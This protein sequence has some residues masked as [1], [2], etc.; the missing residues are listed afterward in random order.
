MLTPCWN[1]IIVK[2]LE[3][4]KSSGTQVPDAL[5]PVRKCKI[6]S[7]GNK[8]AENNGAVLFK[9]FADGI[10]YVRKADLDQGAKIKTEDG[11]VVIISCFDVIA[12]DDLIPKLS[13]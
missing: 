13:K 11:E 4:E 6:I 5:R 2:V 12:I 10:A 1:K 3:E 8:E 7:T 9:N